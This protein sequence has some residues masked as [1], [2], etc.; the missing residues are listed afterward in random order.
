[1]TEL[2]AEVGI[3]RLKRRYGS[4]NALFYRSIKHNT[5]TTRTSIF[6]TPLL[7]FL[8]TPSLFQICIRYE[9]AY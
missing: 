7:T 2:E 6:T 3:G 8:L 1:M 5:A 9:L 4:N